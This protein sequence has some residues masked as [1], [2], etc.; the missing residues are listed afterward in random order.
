MLETSQGL[1]PSGFWTRGTYEHT[2]LQVMLIHLMHTNTK[3]VS[4]VLIF[5]R[6]N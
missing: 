6:L 3:C 4:G 2:V 5:E 1:D